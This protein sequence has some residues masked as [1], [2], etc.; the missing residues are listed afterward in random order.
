MPSGELFLTAPPDGAMRR[1][2]DP[3]GLRLI[4]DRYADVIAPGMNARCTDAHWLLHLGWMLPMLHAARPDLM[5]LEPADR[6]AWLR[7][8]ELLVVRCGL[9][10]FGASHG[11]GAQL[12]GRRAMLPYLDDTHHLRRE[13]FG[14]S[15]HTWQRYRQAGAYGA[16]RTMLRRISGF[17]GL[18]GQEGDG[19]TVGRVAAALGQDAIDHLGLKRPMSVD[20]K[21]SPVEYWW[22]WWRPR[23]DGLATSWWRPLSTK[24]R[25][26]P[27]P[28]WPGVQALRTAFAKGQDADAHA[29]HWTIERM[30]ASRAADEAE[31]L[32]ELEEQHD[33]LH[34]LTAF[35]ALTDHAMAVLEAIAKGIDPDI[36]LEGAALRDASEACERAIVATQKSA[37]RWRDAKRPGWLLAMGS[38]LVDRLAFDVMAAR[39][40]EQAVRVLLDHHREHGHGAPW[41]SLHAGR[42]HLIS[43]VG[44]Q[45]STRYAYRLW[46][47]GR[48]ATQ[49]RLLSAEVVARLWGSVEPE[50]DAG[51]D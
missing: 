45:R 28:S 34:G 33:Q 50:M 21:R 18:E 49:L 8:L 14:M 7:P 38:D 15:Q 12:P 20:G 16:Y 25:V 6:Y 13:R 3:L 51:D 43:T 32:S 39:R 2:S 35:A 40:P 10:S 42:I 30:A 5:D 46:Q 36:D 44:S 31:L 47:L 9:L 24:E 29:R 17:T 4:A 1:R 37:R 48:L 11:N 41:L 27:L 23:W 19:W 22:D 26:N